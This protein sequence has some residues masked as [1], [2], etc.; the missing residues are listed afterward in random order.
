VTMELV[1]DAAET[2]SCLQ[3]GV[4]VIH[5]MTHIVFILNVGYWKLESCAYVDHWRNSGWRHHSPCCLTWTLKDAY[6]LWSFLIL[7]GGP[8][9]LKHVDGFLH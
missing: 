6:C 8:T 5:D 1:S 3:S 4:D 2:H 7:F 9:S